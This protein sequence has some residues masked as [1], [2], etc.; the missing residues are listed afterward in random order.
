MD[1]LWKHTH[2][3][4]KNFIYNYDFESV[5]ISKYFN[6]IRFNLE[7]DMITIEVDVKQV[8]ESTDVGFY[9]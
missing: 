6:D 7:D 4:H 1:V 3:L 8:A 9:L 2:S 5:N